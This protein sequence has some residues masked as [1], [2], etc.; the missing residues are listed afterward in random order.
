VSVRLICVSKPTIDEVPDSQSLLAF[1]A[2]VSSTANQMNHETGG[3]LLRSLVKR[4]E[5]SPLEMVS[6]TVEILTTR[7]IARQ[8]LRHRSFSF[9]EFSQRYA[10][11]E[12]DAV[13]REVR[14]QDSA[15][16]QNSIETQDST[17]ADWWS[18]MQVDHADQGRQLYEQAI[19]RGIAKEVARAVLP[20]GMT[21]SRLYMAGTLRS[22][23][24]YCDLRCDRKTQKEHR[25]IA[26][27]IRD[28]LVGQFP[29]LGGI[30]EGTMGD[31]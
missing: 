9:Q 12:S 18:K 31:A 13:I 8:I 2:R 21:A 3:R 22:W 20:E 10:R 27:E 29:D 17:L 23:I 30:I 4:K 25:V 15:D 19:H 26:C 6:L 24:H 28:L 11:V 16:R 14:L 1:C 5:W 7:D